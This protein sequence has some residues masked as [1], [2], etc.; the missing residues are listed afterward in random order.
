MIILQ[1]LASV[2][3][4]ATQRGLRHAASCHDQNGHGTHAPPVKKQ[5]TRMLGSRSARAQAN[6]VLQALAHCYRNGS[7]C[8]VPRL[9]TS[10]ESAIV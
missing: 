5:C 9:A 7:D 6:L 10:S 2:R 1:T 3:S 4:R 8:L